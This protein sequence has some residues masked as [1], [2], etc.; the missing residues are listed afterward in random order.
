MTT[1]LHL[2]IVVM[3][4]CCQGLAAGQPPAWNAQNVSLPWQGVSCI[5]VSPD[6]TRIAVGTIAP[7]GDPNVIQLSATGRVERQFRVGQ[8]W[9]ES[10]AFG[11]AG[12]LHALCTMPEGRDRDTPTLFVCDAEPSRVDVFARGEPSYRWTMFAYGDASNHLGIQMAASADAIVASTGEAV[13]WLGPT[14][15]EPRAVVRLPRPEGVVAT[16]FAVHASG[17]AVAACSGL[18]ED[19]TQQ[20][21][22]FVVDPGADTPQWS[23]TA[24]T[25]VDSV[26]A[27]EP[28]TYGGPTLPDGSRG[29]LPQRDLPVVAALSIACGTG[30]RLDRIATADY[31][32]WQRWIRSSATGRLAPYGTR[33]VPARPTVSIY[34]GAGSLIRRFEPAAFSGNA[35]VDLAF[36]PGDRFLLA[37]PHRWTSRGLGG[38][39]FLP[40][41]DA[42]KTVW[43]LDIATGAVHGCEFPEAVA[44]VAIDV[45]GRIAVSCWDGRLHLFESIFENSGEA[46]NGAAIG[47]DPAAFASGPPR[48]GIDLGHPAIVMSLAGEGWVAATA[49]GV[50]HILGADCQPRHVVRLDDVV[51]RTEKPWVTAA[52]AE[53]IDEGLWGLPGGRVESDLGRQYAIEAPDGLILIEGHGG[54]SFEREWRALEAVGLDPKR[55]RYVLATHEHGDHAPGAYLWRLATGARFV[56]SEQMAYTLRHHTPVCSGYG[57]H[58]PV[59]A[60][61]IVRGDTDLVLAG[62]KV[63]ALRLPGHTA[64]S[65]GWLVTRGGKRYVAIGD[66]VMPGGALGYSGSVNFSARDVL[67]SLEKLAGLGVDRVLPGHGPVAGPERYLDAALDIGRRDGWGKLQPSADETKNE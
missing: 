46:T 45:H 19:G 1:L 37:F 10:V 29:P 51:D 21:N 15:D 30:P 43:L 9:I 61:V 22:V 6:G 59:P 27:V 56:C 62:A 28:G 34:D 7:A 53:Q 8:R 66:L 38:Q 41:D 57:F 36:L 48:T 47:E 17:R 32:G 64:G 20:G 26:A 35:W 12:R 11:P 50:I 3:V 23:R 4:V 52:R 63:K 40:A 67:A 39:P 42:A 14:G 54:L 25:A 13:A 24:N 65:V 58:P 55:V 49:A 18:K 60:D 31:G 5:D 33:F 2:L 16:A 44:S